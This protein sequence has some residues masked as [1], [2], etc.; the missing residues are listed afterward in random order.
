MGYPPTTYH[1]INGELHGL[2]DI[3]GMRQKWIEKPWDWVEN[4]FGIA[5]REYSVGPA[6]VL[7]TIFYLEALSEDK[8][9]FWIY[10]GWIPRG[11]LGRLKI[12]HMKKYMHKGVNRL[13]TRMQAYVTNDFEGRNPLSTRPPQLSSNAIESAESKRRE[14]LER[15]LPPE[16]A[17]R[18]VEFILQGDSHDLQ[19]IRLRQLAKAWNLPLDDLLLVALH[20]TRIGLTLLSWDVLCPHCRIVRDECEQLSE[21]SN[22]RSCDVCKVL[23]DTSAEN[24]V[25]VTFR[26]H[27]SIRKVNRTVYCAAEIPK[28][29][30]IKFQRVIRPF[31]KRNVS[32]E[33]APGKYALHHI[34]NAEPIV[35]ELTDSGASSTLPPIVTCSGEKTEFELK[36]P[37]ATDD[38]VFYLEDLKWA[39][40]YLSPGDVLSVPTFRDLF[41]EEVL[42]LGVTIEVGE[43]TILFGDLVG[44]TSMYATLGDHAAFARI[45]NHFD[46]VLV[47]IRNANGV[48]VKT[49]GDAIMCAFVDPMDAVRA[50]VAIQQ[51]ASQSDE[52]LPIRISINRGPCLAVN[53]NT[54][55][56][57]FGTVVNLAAK[58]Q[59]VAEEGDI[60]IPRELADSP[61]LQ[62]LI[63]DMKFPTRNASYVPSSDMGE[64][65][66]LVFNVGSKN[67]ETD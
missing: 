65:L 55:L 40:D 43:Q 37:S 41:A 28:K 5:P 38:A 9:T 63:K 32:I 23:F 18:F 12:R 1:E 58:L 54:Q 66:A 29:N 25:E 22:R 57:Y 42:D 56:D 34:G 6:Q 16:A 45:K 19:R 7:R 51:E 67:L 20:A 36:N 35:I 2:I 17:N 24:V 27:P 44:S 30:H 33:L 61:Q 31:E 50:A 39:D 52:F 13:A 8:T 26:V 11:L 46:Q 60:A 14:L 48:L 4:Q 49:I 59:A 3:R 47:H 15:D 21:L 53:F 62:T 64:H 10:Y